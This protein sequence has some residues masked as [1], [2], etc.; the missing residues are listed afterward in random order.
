MRPNYMP[1]M[2]SLPHARRQ[3]VVLAA[4][5][6]GGIGLVGGVSYKETLYPFCWATNETLPNPGPLP[7]SGGGSDHYDLPR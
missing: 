5:L 2:T 4:P 7:L 3:Q 1:A 6:W